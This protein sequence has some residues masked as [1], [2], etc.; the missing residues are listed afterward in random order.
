M[1]YSIKNWGKLFETA[2]TRK[3]KRLTWVP[4]PNKH[5]GKGYRR[6]LRLQDGPLVYAAWVLV[7]QVASKCPTRGVLADDDGPLTAEDIADKTGY[8][9]RYF[10][11]ALKA[12][13]R[14]EIGWLKVDPYPGT[15]G[16]SA[17]VILEMQGRIEGNRSEDVKDFPATPACPNGDAHSANAADGLLFE[18][19]VPKHQN[20][21]KSIDTGQSSRAR[22]QYGKKPRAKSVDGEVFAMLLRPANLNGAHDVCGFGLSKIEAGKAGKM[23]KGKGGSWSA[24][25][26]AALEY[27]VKDRG[28]GGDWLA[29][30]RGHMTGRTSARADFD[31]ITSRWAKWLKLTTLRVQAHNRHVEA[32]DATQ[33]EDARAD[34]FTDQ[35]DRDGG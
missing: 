30:A 27:A 19:D 34:G 1:I 6:I 21:K 5:D 22:R 3:L 2:E 8:P 14:K 33:D 12:L 13:A 35:L 7:L 32:W 20:G 11:I 18:Q 24:H 16:D 26:L 17:G 25:K 29:L 9:V 23:I 28:A 31:E 15:A 4:V 10:E